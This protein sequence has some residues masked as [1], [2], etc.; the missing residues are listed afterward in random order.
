MPSAR[1]ISHPDTTVSIGTRG[2]REGNQENYRERWR[3][4][5]FK[6]EGR[7]RKREKQEQTG[8]SIL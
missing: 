1:G 6:R 2:Q 4:N 5:V 7:R 3:E 8:F